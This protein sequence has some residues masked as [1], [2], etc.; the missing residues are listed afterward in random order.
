MSI[1]NPA[2]QSDPHLSYELGSL[3]LIFSNA[4]GD[5]TWQFLCVYLR[6]P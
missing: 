6:I 5:K 3:G 2:W 1:I 4:E